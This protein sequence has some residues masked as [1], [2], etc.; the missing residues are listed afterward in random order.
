MNRLRD[1]R[2]VSWF[3]AHWRTIGT[4]AA[5]VIVLFGVIGYFAIPAAA[6]WGIET[7]AA[8]ELGRAVTVEKISANPFNL[9]VTFR[10]IA[11]AGNAGEPPLLTVRQATINASAESIL[12][13][14]PVIESLAI[15]APAVNI[16]RYEPERFSFSDVVDRLRSKPK[17][18]DEP[19]QFAV[20]NIRVADGR[21]DLDDRVLAKRHELTEIA[22]GIPF[23]SSLET[24]S[25]VDVEPLFAARIDGAPVAL[26]GETLPFDESL[27]S[28]ITLKLDA[29]DIPKYLAYSPVRL[30]FA[31]GRG[32]LDTNLRI[33]FQRAVPAREDRPARPQRLVVTGS[34]DVDDFQLSAPAGAGTKPLIGWQGLHVVIDEAQVFRRSVVVGEIALTA[35]EI[36]LERDSAGAINWQRFAREPVVESGTTASKG[37]EPAATRSEPLALTLRRITVGDGKLH[38]SDAIAGDFRQEVINLNAEARDLTT[39]S[40]TPGKVRAS[41]LIRDNA[42]VGLAGAVSLAPLAGRLNLA[43]RETRL[44]LTARYLVNVIEADIDGRS[45]VDG[46]LEFGPGD[47][48]PKLALRDI[49]IAGK[50]IKVRGPAGSGAALDIAV[51]GLE[52][53]EIDLAE[54]TIT[55]GKLALDAPRVVVKRLADGEVNWM[56]V[57]RAKDA[58]TLPAAP[59]DSPSDA[60]SDAPAEVPPKAP[61]WKFR[62][63]Q[64]EI[65][66]GDAQFEDLTTEPAVKLRASAITGTVSN[67]AGDGSEPAEFQMRTRFGSGGTLAARG[68]AR[69]DALAV[70]ARLDARNLDVAALRPYFA[71]RLNALLA[72][73][74]LSSRSAVSLR[75]PNRQAPIAIA[76]KGNARVANLHALSADGEE[77]L[78]KWQ[79][80]DIDQ[81]AV[82]TGTEPPTVEL[83]KV[84][85]SDF[86]ARVIVS[87]QGRLNLADLVKREAPTGPAAPEVESVK[88]PTARAESTMPVD[89]DTAPAAPAPAPRTATAT[90][91]PPSDP[92]T[93]PTIRIAQV[94]L[95]RGNVNF[96]DNFIKPNYTA[97]MT[98]LGGTL[99]TLASDNAEPAT[100]ALSGRIDDEAP[101][102]ISGRLN[103]LAP[104]LFLDIEGRTKGVDLPRMTPYSVKYAGYPIVKGKLSMD[105]KYKVEDQKLA[106]S[107]H[108]FV[109]QLTF[110]DKVESPTATKLPVLLA[111]SLLKNSKGEIDINLPISGSLNDPKFSIGGIIV[112]V[113]VNL[114][115]K[116]VTAPF[117]VL[118]AAFGGEELGYIEFAA[119]ASVLAPEQKKRLDSLSKALNDR[120][121]LKLDIIGRVDPAVD[122]EG[123]KRA[124]YDA[125]LRAAKVRQTVRAGGDSIDPAKITIS[126]SERLA[127]IA[128]VYSDEDIPNK[129]RNF[130]GFAK[131]IPAPEME[132]LILANLEVAQEDLRALA[133]QRASAVR[134]YL[135]Q[136]GK[137]SRERLFLVE[138]KLTPEGIQDKGAK[139]RVD[140]SLK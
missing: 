72:K 114:L 140:F 115:T 51:L 78:L 20:Y 132:Q 41:A 25:D 112:Q 136:E 47:P 67:V 96:T 82:K 113:I 107:N 119:G 55:F 94:E 23:L 22:I 120:P 101:L 65:A 31:V 135:E 6:R 139:T 118:A 17:T 137:V 56:R 36:F 26:H 127:L 98:G 138:P 126:D 11:I 66:R 103:P 86:F 92:A 68:D 16:I 59:A 108:L 100:L 53:G 133:N 111:V 131:T 121:A 30:N 74:E 10:G 89:R 52:G 60:P 80:L 42:G 83:G 124:K 61:S 105:V 97:N 116:I 106:A 49:R 32:K 28:S 125:K 128:A 91:A 84:T 44:K 1:N 7:V 43:V 76:L 69:W 85:L 134:N 129:P 71:A 14:A 18:D 33:A 21:I 95:V 48:G 123:T 54:R 117:T 35:P 45:D 15:E 63:K 13:L 64:A 57:M 9:R 75:Q 77:D 12:R 87:E 130:I 70:N 99:S 79:L 81:L 88:E 38:Y 90:L 93:R 19:A 4:A 104:T 109:D 40:S 3:Q 34:F 37:S 8:R 58:P 50:E 122:T 110:G 62:M 27:E 102:E 29:L 24:H 73:A 2:A 46:V 5:G 39:T